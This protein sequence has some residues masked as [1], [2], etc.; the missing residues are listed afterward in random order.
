MINTMISE[1]RFINVVI[2]EG[3]TSNLEYFSEFVI[4]R[5]EKKRG[6]AKLRGHTQDSRFQ[7]QFHQF[8]LISIS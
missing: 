1:M 2:S 6:I 7:R 3:S 8:H 5:G 4:R